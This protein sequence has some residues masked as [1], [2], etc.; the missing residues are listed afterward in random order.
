MQYCNIRDRSIR[1]TFREAVSRGISSDMGLFM[2]ERIPLM[3]PDFF[4]RLPGMTFAEISFEVGGKYTGDEIPAGTLMTLCEEAFNFPVRLRTISDRKHVPELFH[5]PTA[6][7]KD[8]GAR[9]MAQCFRYFSETD[10]LRTVV[11]V[12]TSGD[13]G[14]AI[15]NSFYGMEDIDVI[16]PVSYTHLRA[17]ETDS[18]LVCRLLLE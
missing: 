10:D 14:G 12:A 2:P 1:V 11:L 3:E 9:F 15:A 7:F 5:G 17:H 13:T 18:Y 8:F 4:R 6:A 16:I